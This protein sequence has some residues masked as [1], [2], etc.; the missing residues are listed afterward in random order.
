[1]PEMWD[2]VKSRGVPLATVAAHHGWP[3]IAP[4]AYVGDGGRVYVEV[5][6]EDALEVAVRAARLLLTRGRG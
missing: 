6:A 1:M 4:G 5:D 3:E 2:R